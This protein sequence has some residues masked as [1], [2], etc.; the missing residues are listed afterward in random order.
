MSI[1]NCCNCGRVKSIL[2]LHS[3]E[4]VDQFLMGLNDS[5]S[6]VRAHILLTDPLPPLNKVFSLI[7]QEE[8]QREITVNSMSHESAALL[9]KF[10]LNPSSF[11][12]NEPTA[13][14]TKSIPGSRFTKQNFRKHICSHCGL[15]GHTIEKCYKL[16]GF[17][18]GFKFTKTKPP[19]QYSPSQHSA[20]Q[21]QSSNQYSS[22]QYLVNQIQSP[23]Q[24]SSPPYLVNQVQTTTSSSSFQQLSSN[25]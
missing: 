15:S 18:P 2:E 1:C 20:N 4:R 24:Y 5:F 25:E 10:V 9:T 7:I 17:P 12:M 13:L 19:N 6:A 3:Q 21:L 23:H 11:Q 8:K 22:P 16:H 14:M